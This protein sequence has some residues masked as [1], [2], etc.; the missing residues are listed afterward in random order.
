MGSIPPF[1]PLM[2]PGKAGLVKSVS[3]VDV[4]AIRSSTSDGFVRAKV[5]VNRGELSNRVFITRQPKTEEEYS[6]K[7][8][9]ADEIASMKK[10]DEIRD[11]TINPN[12]E[13][14]GVVVGCSV[15]PVEP[16][17][18]VE[19]EPYDRFRPFLRKRRQ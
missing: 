5:R 1:L 19:P 3:E 10:A 12:A 17:H 15:R 8:Y 6:P 4:L 13:V 14:V 18:L 2:P 9:A 7:D 11:R 16:F